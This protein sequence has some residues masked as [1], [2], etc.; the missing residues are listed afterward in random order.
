[1]HHARLRRHRPRQ[2]DASG[3]VCALRAGLSADLA[4]LPDDHGGVSRSRQPRRVRHRRGS[5]AKARPRD[6][7]RRAMGERPLGAG[8]PRCLRPLGRAGRICTPLGSAPGPRALCRTGLA[9][10]GGPR[11]RIL[12]DPARTRTPTIRSSRRSGAPAV[13]RRRRRPTRS[14]RS[15]NTTFSSSISTTMRRRSASTST[16]SSRRAVQHS[17]RS[18]CA[19]ATRSSSP[20]KCSCSSG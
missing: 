18:T 1:M 16:P 15:T 4:V 7:A 10:G 12:S 17:S 14:P 2:G 9:A 20:T 6:D 8:D 13:R 3:Q 5:R 11:A 19:T